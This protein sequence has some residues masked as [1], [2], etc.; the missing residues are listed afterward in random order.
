MDSSRS[1]GSIDI[2]QLMGFA[3]DEARAALAHDDVP[4]GALVVRVATARS[5][6]A[7]TTNASW[8]AIRPRTRSCS[9]SPTPRASG[10]A[11]GST[12]ARSS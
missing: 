3:L 8:T 10:Q 7:A 2:E 12:T 1:E 5:S 4:V 11:G 6:R 9:R